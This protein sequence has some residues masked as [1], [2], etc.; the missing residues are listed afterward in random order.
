MKVG[1]VGNTRYPGL[2]AILDDLADSA[3]R[4]G[5]EL[6]AEAPLLELWHGAAGSLDGVDLD[7]L[8]TLGGDGTLLRGA[9]ELGPRETPILGVNVGRLGFLTTVSPDRL[10]AALKAISAGELTVERRQML[11]PA[12]RSSGGA[13]RHL[14]HALNDVVVHKGGVARVVRL[15]VIIE[16]EVVGPFS[17]DGMVVA[18][19]T[20]STAYS[21]SAG[22]PVIVPGVKAMVITPI[23]AHTLTVRPV[24]VP[25]E[26]MVAI[27]PLPPWSDEDLLVSLDGQTTEP[28]KPGDRVEIK[29]AEHSLL[30][31]RAGGDSYFNRMRQKLHWGDLYDRDDR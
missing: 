18:T 2:G 10:P 19:P 31:A 29:R 27:E 8:V 20:G 14:H 6:Y 28:L 21:L 26:F 16:G 4:Q 24:V 30:L 22:G 9:R 7:L 3:A 17:V 13:V 15:N 12:I 5:I 11:A 1:V 25:A 23:C